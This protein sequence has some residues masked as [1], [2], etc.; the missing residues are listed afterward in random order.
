ML[1]LL[2]VC[3]WPQDRRKEL[4]KKVNKMSEDCKVAIRNVRKDILKRLDK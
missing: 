3:C 4:S 2:N 1:T